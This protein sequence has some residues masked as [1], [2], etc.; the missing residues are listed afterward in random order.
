MKN[1]KVI[2]DTNAYRDLVAPIPT[3]DI[4]PMMERLLPLEQSKGIEAMMSSI[5]AEEILG[6]LLDDEQ[7]R[8]YRACI[9]ATKAMYLHCGNDKQFRVIPSPQTQIALEYFGVRSK[10]FEDTQLALGQ[11]AYRISKDLSKANVLANEGQLKHV[12]Q[13]LQ[14]S[15][16][17]LADAV[18]E[19]GRKMDPAYTDWNLFKGNKSMRTKYLNYVRSQSFRIEVAAGILSA[20]GINLECEGLIKTPTKPQFDSMIQTYMQ[21]YEPA[22]NMQQLFYEL[23]LQPDFDITQNS[24]ANYLWDTQILH[25]V[26]HTIS[27]DDILLVTSD[28]AMI[29]QADKSISDKVMNLDEYKAFVGL[30]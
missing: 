4:E 22:L 19:M 28:K 29:R 25:V 3:N 20:V 26:G 10:R 18:L 24:H 13:H 7:T 15:E 9:K 14:T 11:L 2:F 30:K 17:D 5:T 27:G 23:V 6:H 21:S 1:M 8:T 12:K 16:Q